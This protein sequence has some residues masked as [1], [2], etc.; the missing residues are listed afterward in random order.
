MNN[1][2]VVKDTARAKEHFLNELAYSLGPYELK[3]K[4]DNHLDSINLVDV[5][6]YDDYIDGHIPFAEHIPAMEFED[7]LDKL[8][9][10]KINI[11]YC[12][13]MECQLAK[14]CIMKAL[15]HGFP[16]MELT[17]G[18]KSW[19]DYDFDTIKTSATDY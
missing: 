17:G 1:F 8:S 3:E 18:F 12:Y 16:S 10:D 13:R 6:A 5:R 4:L 15:K 14:K 9:K 7:N 19:K 11:F 2:D